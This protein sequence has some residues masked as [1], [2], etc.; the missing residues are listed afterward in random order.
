MQ[1]A[2]DGPDSDLAGHLGA[3]LHQQGTQDIHGGLHGARRSQHLG[4]EQVARPELD[5][6]VFHPRHQPLVEDQRRVQAFLQRLPREDRRGGHIAFDHLLGQLR[7]GCRSCKVSW[8]RVG[9]DG[10]FSAACSR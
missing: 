4:D 7:E 1:V 3:G 9:A 6:D 5:P 2:F 8:R 10:Q